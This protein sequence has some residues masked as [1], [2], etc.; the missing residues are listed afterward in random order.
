MFGPYE[1]EI[2]GRGVIFGKG[3]ES[4]SLQQSDR[5]IEAR[6]TELALVVAIGNEVGDCQMFTIRSAAGAGGDPVDQ[7]ISPAAALVVRPAS[8]SN[9]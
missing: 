4:T 3:S 7:C 2:V 9:A 8:V 6:R 5:K 1:V